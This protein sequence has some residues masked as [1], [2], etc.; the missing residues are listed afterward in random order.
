MPN[1][2]PRSAEK[3]HRDNAAQLELIEKFRQKL[4]KQLGR[5]ITPNE[6][7]RIWILTYAKEWRAKRDAMEA[8]IKGGFIA[9]EDLKNPAI[10]KAYRDYVEE[11]GAAHI[12]E[13]ISL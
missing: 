3:Q 10:T 5:E 6:A 9:F 7:A 1:L 12:L 4:I 2:V 8:L 11:V 13:M